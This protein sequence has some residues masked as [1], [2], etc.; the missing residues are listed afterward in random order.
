MYLSD[1]CGPSEQMSARTLWILECAQGAKAGRVAL[2][3]RAA[4]AGPVESGSM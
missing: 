2:S 4:P 1:L 3:A